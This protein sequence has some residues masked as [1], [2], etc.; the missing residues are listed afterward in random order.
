[1][2]RR[3]GTVLCGDWSG[4]TVRARDLTFAAGLV[5]WHWTISCG[6]GCVGMKPPRRDVLRS[7]MDDVCGVQM[8][9]YRI[10]R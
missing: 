9:V 2:L 6:R 8:T 7:P 5:R 10:L 3:R 1:M 4:G